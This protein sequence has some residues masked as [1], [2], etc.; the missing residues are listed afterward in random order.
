M[1]HDEFTLVCLLMAG[2]ANY[3]VEYVEK[4]RSMV[5]RNLIGAITG[6]T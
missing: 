2:H 4:L 3:S 1:S 6:S 5:A